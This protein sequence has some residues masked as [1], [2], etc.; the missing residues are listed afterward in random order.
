MQRPGDMFPQV[1]GTLSQ[2]PIGQSGLPETPVEASEITD[3]HTKLAYQKDITAD[4]AKNPQF[5][6]LYMT[7]KWVQ[8][9]NHYG[10]TSKAP[11]HDDYDKACN[12]SSR[13]TWNDARLKFPKSELLVHEKV[14]LMF[15]P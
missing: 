12:P 10:V 3:I 8:P 15:N 6:Q 14:P 2:F 9:A 7:P 11:Q 5:S 1:K 4:P 13:I